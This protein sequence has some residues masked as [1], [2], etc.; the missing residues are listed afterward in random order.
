[1]N[2]S[3]PKGMIMVYSLHFEITGNIE[4]VGKLLEITYSPCFM[5]VT[6]SGSIKP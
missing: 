3:C 2:H 1:M 6:S 4:V 5:F